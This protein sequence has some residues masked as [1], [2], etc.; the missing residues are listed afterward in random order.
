MLRA[1]LRSTSACFGPK[2]LG[3]RRICLRRSKFFTHGGGGLPRSHL[4]RRPAP[5][6]LS[7]RLRGG[8]SGLARRE[9]TSLAASAGWHLSQAGT[10]RAIYGRTSAPGTCHMAYPGS[11]SKCKSSANPRASRLPRPYFQA[12]DRSEVSM[13]HGALP[14]PA[15]DA[16]ATQVSDLL[17]SPAS[18]TRHCRL[19]PAAHLWGLHV[20]PVDSEQA[21]ARSRNERRII[22]YRPCGRCTCTRALSCS[23]RGNS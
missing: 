7:H 20:E 6:L 21:L 17:D 12:I 2:S 23:E 8:V 19:L 3:P 22:G 18:L 13:L 4:P 1:N 10:S 15:A 14:L 5:A 16:R 11:E 9:A